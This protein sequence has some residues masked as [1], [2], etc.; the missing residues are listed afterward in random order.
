VFEKRPIT[1]ATPVPVLIIFFLVIWSET[2][3]GVLAYHKLGSILPF[4]DVVV[5][6]SRHILET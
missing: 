1:N 6:Q 3:V 4:L 2:G 5:Y